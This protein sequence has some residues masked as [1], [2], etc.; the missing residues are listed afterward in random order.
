M[1]VSWHIRTNFVL[2]R[3]CGC[4]QHQIP[5]A[6]LLIIIGSLYECSFITAFKVLLNDNV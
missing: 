6:P 5:S 3:M 4:K 1:C 2:V